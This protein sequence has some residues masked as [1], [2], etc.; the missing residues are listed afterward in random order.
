MYA[1]EGQPGS[2]PGKYQLT[3]CYIA[4]SKR[5]TPSDMPGAKYAL[6]GVT[7]HVFG[8]QQTRSASG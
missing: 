1:V 5:C 3:G 2:C 8:N 7:R 4:A 6:Q